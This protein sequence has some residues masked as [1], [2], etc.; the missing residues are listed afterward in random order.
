MITR[1]MHAASNGVILTPP[2]PSK[3]VGNNA[4]RNQLKGSLPDRLDYSN[5]V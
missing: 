1:S 4:I 3:V 2:V 5:D